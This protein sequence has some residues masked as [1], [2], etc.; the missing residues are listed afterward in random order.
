MTV[1]VA[2]LNGSL[3]IPAY[4]NPK[5]F[6]KTPEDLLRKPGQAMTPA[7]MA[8]ALE[9]LVGDYGDKDPFKDK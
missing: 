8:R 4:H 1:R 7:E 3:M 2:W 6:P 9:G 5:K